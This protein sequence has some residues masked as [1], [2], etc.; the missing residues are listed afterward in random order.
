M[1]FNAE[2]PDLR[3]C[4][5]G[6]AITE[7]GWHLGMRHFR[8]EHPDPGKYPVVLCHGLG[9]NGTFWTITDDHL[10]AQLAARGYEVFVVDLRGSGASH[11]DGLLGKINRGLRQTPLLEI[12]EGKWTVDDQSFQDVPA[13]LHYV[14]AAT[15]SPKVN[16][17]GHSLGGMLI[18]PFLEFSPEAGRI[19]SY[20]GMGATAILAEAPQRDMLRANR[21]LRILLLGISTGR[22]AR[23]MMFIRPPNMGAID[24]FYFTPEVVDQRTVSR[25]YGYTLENPGR[26][27]LKQLDPYLA[28][29]HMLSADR[30]ID[31]AA[32]LGRV[33]VPTLLVAGE[34]D[35][36]S[37]IPSTELTFDALGSPDKTLIR[38][39]RREGQVADYGHCDLV[40]SRNAPAEVFPALADWLDLH[41]PGVWPSS[42]S[43]GPESTRGASGQE[44]VDA[45]LRPRFERRSHAG[46]ALGGDE[47]RIRQP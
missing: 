14:E 36:M 47:L 25:F 43:P 31:Y 34:A 33:T 22:A 27:A 37:D 13:I 26:G 19:A 5:D 41:Q 12:K 6:F 40:W 46:Q 38:F 21:G 32:H 10:P 24:R 45:D 44:G 4:T 9:L 7:D 8:P 28:C 20:V 11:R 2:D 42:Q 39:G 23:P 3:P 1:R 18:Y 15:G 30:Q 17:V 35:I 16:W 29:G